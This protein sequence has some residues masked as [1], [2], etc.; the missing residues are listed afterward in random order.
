MYK[1]MSGFTILAFRRCIPSRCLA[2]YYV[3]H[4]IKPIAKFPSLGNIYESENYSFL[5]V[6][7]RQSVSTASPGGWKLIFQLTSWRPP[8]RVMGKLARGWRH[9]LITISWLAQGPCNFSR[10]HTHTH[11]HVHTASR[12]ACQEPAWLKSAM[13][14]YFGS[15][16]GRPGTVTSVY[17]LM[18]RLSLRSFEFSILNYSVRDSDLWIKNAIII[19]RSGRVLTKYTVTE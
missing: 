10:T 18:L 14:P 16:N 9:D 1:S 7:R 13:V 4:S 19:V 17:F 15:E 6:E 2:N 3:R 12:R 8:C 11:T 5:T